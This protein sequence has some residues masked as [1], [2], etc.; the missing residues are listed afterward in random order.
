MASYVMLVRWTEQ[1]IRTVKDSPKRVAAAT[2]LAQRMGVKIVE[3]FWTLGRY[4]LVIVAEAANDETV[5]AWALQVGSHGNVKTQTLR[6]FR[7]RE[8]DRILAKVR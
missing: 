8:M 4:D 5:T 7:A 3:V 6:A 2:S 1:G